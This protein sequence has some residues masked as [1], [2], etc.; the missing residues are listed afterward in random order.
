MRYINYIS[1]K[2]FLSS[3]HVC[4]WELDHK[5]GW[6][7]KNWCFWIAVLENTLE[8]PMDSKDIKPVN[9]KGN[10]SWLFIGRT[11]A[12]AEA[13]I[14]WTPDSKNQLIGK[15][16]DAGKDW[17]QAK[18]A[19]EDEMVGWHHWL[20]GHESEQTPGESGGQRSLACYSPQGLRVRPDLVTEQQQS[21]SPHQREESNL[22]RVG[23]L[24]CMRG[25]NSELWGVRGPWRGRRQ[26]RD[27]RA[28][29]AWCDVQLQ[30]QPAEAGKV[31]PGPQHRPGLPLLPTPKHFY[32]EWIKTQLFPTARL[33]HREN[34]GVRKAESGIK[35]WLHHNHII[36]ANS[37]VIA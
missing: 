27:C 36:Q 19:A 25:S 7:T 3:S 9:P 13:L 30:D 2:L 4:M 33:R 15:G 35:N 16:F 11:A 21:C 6:A 10:Q 32:H 18:G 22:R 26:Q 14:L 37:G 34:T 1:I 5:E 23:L 8:S 28:P 12:E 17:G 24:T 31:R 20:N 29:K